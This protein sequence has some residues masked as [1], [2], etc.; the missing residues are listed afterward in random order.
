[1][2][3]P[4]VLL[5]LLLAPPPRPAPPNPFPDLIQVY[6]LKGLPFA[7]AVADVNADGR[8]D[9]IA[10]EDAAA[11]F[12]A[13]L[14]ASGGGAFRGV[15]HVPGGF[16][17]QAIHPRDLNRDGR[18]D[19]VVES[20]HRAV[21][22]L[23]GT[24]LGFSE[25]VQSTFDKA[26]P[27]GEVAIGSLAVADLDSDGR[28]E[29]VVSSIH[30]DEVLIA[31][32]H[33]DR[34]FI[35]DGRLA[36]GDKPE[37]LIAVDLNLD[38][39]VDIVT[40][41]LES[42]DLSVLLGRGDGTFQ[43]ESRVGGGASGP[44]EGTAPVLATADWNGDRVPDLLV[45]HGGGFVSMLGRGDGTFRQGAFVAQPSY[46][47]SLWTGDIDGD[48][49]TD[50]AF[51]DYGQSLVWF[52]IGKGDGSFHAGD[53][54]AVCA[55]PTSVA[56]ADFGGD[57]LADL[58][59]TCRDGGSSVYLFLGRERGVRG[60]GPLV[61]RVN[62]AEGGVLA[63]ADIDRDGLTDVVVQTEVGASF[64]RGTMDG[65]FQ[66]AVRLKLPLGLTA[67]AI[68]DLNG[69]GALDIAGAE[70]A[71]RVDVDVGVVD[72][73][74]GFVD[75]LLGDGLGGF[76]SGGRYELNG[77]YASLDVIDLDHDGLP[78]LVFGT[79]WRGLSVLPGRTGGS[80]GARLDFPQQ[81]GASIVA[82]SDI[83]GN[84]RV[85]VVMT[86]VE[87]R[88]QVGDLEL[89]LATDSSG[90]GPSTHLR[91]D[92][93]PGRGVI[94]DV[95]SDGHADLVAC[96][97]VF[98]GRG[99]GTFRAVFEGIGM[100]PLLGD[101]DGDQKLDLASIDHFGIL[102][103]IGRGDGTFDEAGRL[104]FAGGAQL[105]AAADLDG[106]ARADLLVGVPDGILVLRSA[107]RNRGSRKAP[108]PRDQ[109][110]TPA[111]S[112]SASAWMRAR[113]AREL[114]IADSRASSASWVM[115]AAALLRLPCSTA[116]ESTSALVDPCF[117]PTNGFTSR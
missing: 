92:C 36:V 95:D 113:S 93:R 28:D 55:G 70:M 72:P 25:P 73:L 7:S 1:M 109:A 23:F 102:V 39:A 77:A 45:K 75:L 11:T 106:D 21:T 54:M 81:A 17:I 15:D 62:R 96:G 26:G 87:P 58:A 48:G 97:T 14:Q 86:V 20:G 49:I 115:S 32:D 33:G 60:F 110:L 82:A 101:F 61:S 79:G 19:I 13:I 114:R 59:V 30:S 6:K 78:D 57:G 9:L 4:V 83:D 50:L 89:F 2:I 22:V 98:L 10:G 107:V 65:A 99:D 63:A 116:R 41:N 105:L 27:S 84:R 88:K 18:I 52:F 42:H 43:P 100:T 76:N 35:V 103:S 91:A 46:A 38:G 66:P 69:D 24:P 67:L 56:I 44:S 5:A 104:S 74:L 29:L 31:R 112:A 3:T 111:A 12:I 47:T 108:L 51:E 16:S 117:F 53:R 8:P 34:H 71:L 68:G 64:L 90:F 37:P 40:M 80:F 85:D 94:G